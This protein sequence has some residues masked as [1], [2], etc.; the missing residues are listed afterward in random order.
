MVDAL[1]RRREFI[2]WDRDRS[3]LTDLRGGSPSTP[4]AYPCIRARNASTESTALA[5]QAQLVLLRK[6]E[7]NMAKAEEATA[8]RDQIDHLR[9]VIAE[10]CRILAQH[11]LVSGS[12]GHVSHRVPGSDDILVRGRPHVD[13]GLRY[14]EPHSIIRVDSNAK[15]VGDTEGVARV[16]EIYLHTETYK[17]RPDVNAVIHAHPPGA[18][19]CS[20][21]N[22]PLNPLFAGFNPG[23]YSMATDGIP[24]YDRSITLQTVEQ[25]LPMLDALGDKDSIL[26][27]RHGVLVVGRSVEEATGRALTFETLCRIAWMTSPH[28]PPRP[29]N[30]LDVEEM[31]RRSRESAEMAAAGRSRF[32]ESHPGAAEGSERRDNWPYLMSL[33]DSGA[34]Y[35]DDIGLGT[36]FPH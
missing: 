23:A 9:Q 12:T 36:R 14:A 13:N 3:E 29:L 17:R 24:V 1:Y 18:L 26:L 8:S 33:L 35:F 5:S 21:N 4:I 2:D 10:S 6:A 19:L 28:E 7:Q 22:V 15:P 25:T 16:S 31:S 27:S 30:P 32:R 20:I 34:L 11:G